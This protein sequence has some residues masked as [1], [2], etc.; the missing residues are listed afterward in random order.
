MATIKTR[1]TADGATRYTAIVR[2]RKGQVILHRESKT[3]AFRSAALSWAKS[4]EVELERP[5][6]LDHAQQGEISLAALIRWYIDSFFEIAAWQRTKQTSLEFLEKHQ[7]GEV[8]ALRITSAM[9]VDH[10]RRRRADGTGPA[11]VAK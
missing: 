5:G 8:N 3:F 2:I 6:A 11:T 7:I 9:L 1:K 10:V 4:R